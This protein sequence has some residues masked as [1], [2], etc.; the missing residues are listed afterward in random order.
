[1]AAGEPDVH[2]ICHRAGAIFAA[3]AKL[4]Y[5]LAGINRW[6]WPGAHGRSSSRCRVQ[7]SEGE[8]R[9]SRWV[10]RQCRRSLPASCLPGAVHPNCPGRST[11]RSGPPAPR[12]VEA[13][14]RFQRRSLRGSRCPTLSPRSPWRAPDL[15]AANP[16]DQWPGSPCLPPRRRGRPRAVL[17]ATWPDAAGLRKSSPATGRAVPSTAQAICLE[18]SRS[19]SPSPEDRRQGAAHRRRPGRSGTA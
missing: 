7:L 4:P 18:R 5:L 3:S 15:A 17:G 6:G 13:G 11:G 1:M 8:E 9:W 2:R 16:A 12:G 10:R 19:R 14:Y